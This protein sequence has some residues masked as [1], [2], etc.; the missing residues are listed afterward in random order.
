MTAKAE[1]DYFE[2]SD[3]TGVLSRHWLTIAMLAMIG[4]ILAGAVYVVSPK[5]YTSTVLVEVSP[6]PADAN[7]LGGH[8]G[9]GIVM[10]NEA[11]IVKSAAVVAKVASDIHST[12]PIGALIKDVTVTAPPNTTFL[13]IACTQRT[14]ALAQQCAN[15]LGTEY[16]KHRR[17]SAVALLNSEISALLGRVNYLQAKIQQDSVKRSVLPKHTAERALLGVDISVKSAELTTLTKDIKLVHPL[18]TSLGSST[19]IAGTVATPANLPGRA[20]SPH[21][22]IWLPSG[23]VVGLIAGL[24]LAFYRDRRGRR[25]HAARDLERLV[26]LPA[27]FVLNDAKQIQGGPVAAPWSRAGQSFSELGQY[28]GAVLGD[29]P[30]VV[31]VVGTAPSGA[32]LVATNVAAALARSRGETVLLTRGSRGGGPGLAEVLVGTATLSDVSRRAADLPRLSVISVVLDG[33]GTPYDLQ[34]DR[35]SIL[36]AELR[37]NARFVVIDVASADT[38]PVAFSLAEFADGAILVA[39]VE[40]SPAEVI[41]DCAVRLD[42]LRTPVLAAAVLPPG[43]LASG[44][45]EPPSGAKRSRYGRENPVGQPMTLPPPGAPQPTPSHLGEP[46]PQSSAAARARRGAD[47]ARPPAGS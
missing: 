7:F 25:I 39:Q 14:P 42:R 13:Q 37:E 47:T 16:L 20:S 44:R 40:A 15:A 36:F 10:D 22:L 32:S 26:D 21:A 8:I 46:W 17:L 33:T 2:L 12:Q 11:Q 41:V 34:Y 24:L 3:Y 30:H 29:G 27:V 6:L 18:A 28:A 4:L 9:G 1:P 45:V 19:T 35:L 23:F 43:R 38:D 31:L 5:T